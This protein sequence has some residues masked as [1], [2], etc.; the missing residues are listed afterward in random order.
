MARGKSG[1]TAISRGMRRITL[2]S[3]SSDRLSG[4]RRR[5]RRGRR[6][7]I[8]IELVG[9][10]MDLFF[11][12]GSPRDSLS[13][14]IRHNCNRCC[15]CCWCWCWCS[16]SCLRIVIVVVAEQSQNDAHRHAT[17]VDAASTTGIATENESNSE[18]IC[19]F[20]IL[21][22]FLSPITNF[23]FLSF[24]NFFFFIKKI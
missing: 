18:R 9:R 3:R 17:A 12:S 20:V 5:G 6:D 4:K 10:T 7:G 16:S 23:P 22:F 11:E 21:S 15:C 8:V 14:P 1:G 13:P 19:S 24:F 2:T